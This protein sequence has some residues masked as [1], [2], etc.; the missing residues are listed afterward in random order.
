MRQISLLTILL[1]VLFTSCNNTNK[2][3]KT[4][5]IAIISIVEIDPIVQLRKGFKNV[6]DSSEFAKNNIIK[7][8]EYNAQNDASLQ[9]QIIDKISINKPNLIYAL[10]TPIAQAVQKRMPEI[11]LVQGTA[12]DPVSAGLANSWDGSGKNYIATTDLPPI[13]KQI[14]LI[15]ALTPT[16]KKLGIIYNPGEINSVAVISRLKKFISLNSI[17]I[18]L[19]ER[20][21]STTAD[22]ATA[23][24]SLVGK[25]DA[26][27]L[28]PDNTAHAAIPLIGKVSNE[29][30]IPFY[31][32]VESAINDGALAT[33]SLDFYEMGKETARLA[34]EVL[35]GKDP[36]TLPIRANKNP[37]ITINAKIANSLNI[38]LSSFKNKPNYKIEN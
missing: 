7:Y 23:I 18:K 38:D 35:N 36:K 6:F 26:V 19:V 24:N 2:K 3:H 34:L 20:P 16:A 1:I 10:G 25:V 9:N 5:D 32:T 22:V 8:S 12:T 21:I 11:L 28:P 37:M 15:Q 13:D 30:N 14:E 31:A 4:F 29:Y 17:D 33:L 27:Y